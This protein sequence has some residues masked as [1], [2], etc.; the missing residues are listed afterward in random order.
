[1]APPSH[2]QHERTPNQPQN[3]EL[4]QEQERLEQGREKR[5]KFTYAESNLQRGGRISGL[6]KRKVNSAEEIEHAEGMEIEDIEEEKV[7]SHFF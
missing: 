1:M 6:P 5:K 4:A 3:D 2:D 7:I